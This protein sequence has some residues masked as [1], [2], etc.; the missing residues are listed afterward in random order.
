[1]LKKNFPHI[2][3]KNRCLQPYY[4][5]GLGLQCYCIQ[6]KEQDLLELLVCMLNNISDLVT[7]EEDTYT[8]KAMFKNSWG[9]INV[10]IAVY[11]KDE[12]TLVVEFQRLS[13]NQLQ[14]FKQVNEI[15]DRYLKALVE[16]K[17]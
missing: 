5:E 17:V 11:R 13:G 7:L 9:R 1:M 12:E 3:N 4:M 14:Y 15:R 10:Q 2:D 16:T 6:T 8:V